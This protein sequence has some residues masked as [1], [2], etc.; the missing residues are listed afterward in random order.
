MSFIGK[1]THSSHVMLSFPF[2][3]IHLGKLGN[4]IILYKLKM[5]TKLK[6]K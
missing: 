5:I 4:I 6:I 1:F 2:P 3:V